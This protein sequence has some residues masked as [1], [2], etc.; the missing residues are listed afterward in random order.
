M[1]EQITIKLSLEESLILC[2]CNI[3]HDPR[4]LASIESLLLNHLDWGYIL[5]IA[6]Q[7]DIASVIFH[8]IDCC[9]NKSLIPAHII[10][11]FKKAYHISAFKNLILLKEYD[12]IL[13][14][15]NAAQIKTM[16]LK[17]IAFLKELY[18][19][20]IALR[21]LADIDILVPKEDLLTAQRALENLGYRLKPPVFYMRE[22]H[23]H[24]VFYKQI[25]NVTIPVELHWDIDVSDSAFNVI[26]SDLWERA[27]YVSAGQYSY[28]R[29]CID[30]I[31]LI[32]GFYILR[33]TY[34]Q[35]TL[36]S[37]KNLW[38][39]SE[40]IKRQHTEINWNVIIKRAEG[41]NIK[42]SVLLGLLLAKELLDD[43]LNY[44]VMEMIKK[45]GFKDETLELIIKERIFI[46]NT[47][48]LSLPGGL[49][50]KVSKNKTSISISP[51][52]IARAIYMRCRAKHDTY[53]S[54]TKSFKPIGIMLYDSLL[55]YLKFLF[56]S[57]IDR[58]ST[59]ALLAQK[60][61]VINRL[62][63]VDDWLRGNNQS[64]NTISR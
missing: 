14:N 12:N 29:P 3:N 7:H 22:R 46:K 57:I 33:N 32:M 34:E 51:A 60:F 13:N 40:I 45:E 21:A 6:K 20:N 4:Q 10:D 27:E 37:L 50:L 43:A 11:E 1:I 63:K 16:P 49:S 42:R 61:S 5:R 62:N 24:H 59:K 54:F 56:Q 36:V 26:I 55:N 44:N 35:S 52:S 17:G 41:Y 8:S 30:D 18:N 28:Y 58:K 9:K 23:F 53:Q 47:D 2:C 25:H 48:Y 31:I 38:D 39:L 15:F 19:N 64:N